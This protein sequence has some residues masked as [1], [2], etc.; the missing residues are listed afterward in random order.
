M[1]TSPNGNFEIEHPTGV[2]K[3]KLEIK[4]ENDEIV[5]LIAGTIRHARLIMSGE[6]H[7][8]RSLIE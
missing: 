7:V 2:S 4:Y 6:V 3:V 5:D 1:T 8:Q